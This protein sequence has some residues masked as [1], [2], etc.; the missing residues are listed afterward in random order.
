MAGLA[1]DRPR[2]ASSTIPRFRGTA[3]SVFAVALAMGALIHEWNS[4][5]PKWVAIPVA[6]A[7]LVVL[8]RPSS[9]VRLVALLA[10]LIVECASRLPNPVNH[11][12]LLAIL[13]LAAGLWWVV[14]RLR[15]PAIAADPAQLYERIAP[16]LRVG[17]ITMWIFAAMAKMNSGFMDFATS[18]AVW[19]LE[20]APGVQVPRSL[21][22]VAIVGTIAVELSIP[23]LLLFHRTRPFAILVAF[24]FHAMSAISGHSWFSGFAWAF[25]A[26]F[27]PPVTLARGTAMARRGVE[28]LGERLPSWVTDL[29]VHAGRRPLP[30]LAV[31]VLGWVGARYLVAPVLP[32]S[33]E[34]VRHAG[35][36]LMCL[37]WMGVTGWI[38]FRLRE[39]W[40]PAP[41]RPKAG[42]R[43]TSPILIL[44][45]V[46]LVANALAPYAGVKTRAS[47]T[48]FSNLQ[49]EP[50][51]W[52]SLVLPESARVFTWLDGGDVTFVDVEDPGLEA[53]V[54]EAQGRTVVL[55]GA[56]RIAR[57]FPEATVRYR[58]DGVERIA[59][60][61]A[62]DPIL[63][64]PL[65][66][67]EDWFGS[68]RPYPSTQDS[69]LH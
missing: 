3:F 52:N 48:M 57:D 42:L 33:L 62:A 26:L 38:L 1:L 60:P 67:A 54:E 64:R 12:A 22:G 5:F 17:F 41:Q 66:W 10:A 20:S 61:V 21:T 8:L 29:A 44:G 43:F 56:R 55:L 13:G 40:L 27:L 63:G 2:Q 49:T 45:I 51:H 69:C 6:V 39:S 68:A 28:R 16:F 31:L 24:P 30:T 15:A 25:Y 18:C 36:V 46:V 50:G 35:A 9:P 23:L 34:Q 14:L 37:A 7:A 47:F 19:I 65:S 59:D 32:G 53:A 4:S 11:Q 58:L